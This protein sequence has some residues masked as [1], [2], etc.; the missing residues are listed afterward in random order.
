MP[1]ALAAGVLSVVAPVFLLIA[2]GYL[3]IRIGLFPQDGL[4]IL[5]QFVIRCSVPVLL[6]KTLSQRHFAE[7]LDFRYLAAYTVGSLVAMGATYAWARTVRHKN[8]GEA[9]IYG[10]GSSFANSAF[11]GYP[12]A[13]QALG[14]G[15]SLGLALTM[16]VESIVMLPLCL[17]LTEPGLQREGRFFR[18]VLSVLA[19]LRTNPIIVAILLGLVCAV[20]TVPLPAPVLKG[21]DLLAA[22]SAPVALFVLGGNLHGTPIRGM[23]ADV[24]VVSLGKLVLHPL[25]VLAGVLLFAP[26]DP[27]LGPTAVLLA[28][29]SPMTIYP[30]LG[31]R[32]QLE[33]FCSAVLL[34]ATLAAFATVSFVL[35]L[36]GSF[37]V[38][39]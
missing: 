16:T 33:R 6:F 19:R 35:I 3:A 8:V 38:L 31:E 7:I 17:A 4:P 39:A 5:G 32:V 15:A 20:F 11:L 29:M 27:V 12:I 1:D 21:V 10:I 24:T 30:I 34:V 18:T 37:R 26:T 36:L 23:A 13:L 28:S 14:P 2:A 25:L 22:S 9:A